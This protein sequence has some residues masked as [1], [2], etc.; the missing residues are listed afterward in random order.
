MLL[1]LLLQ[2]T[3]VIRCV[4]PQGPR[5]SKVVYGVRL[6]MKTSGAAEGLGKESDVHKNST[7]Y[8]NRV[9]EATEA[10]SLASVEDDGQERIRS[11]VS[12]SLPPLSNF[13]RHE[14]KRLPISRTTTLQRI[15]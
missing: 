9:R 15:Q 10:I 3:G 2:F 13:V 12:T 5:L 14:A 7:G 4:E 6:L 8:D 1:L 11:E